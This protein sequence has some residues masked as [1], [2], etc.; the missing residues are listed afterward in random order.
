M[1]RMVPAN[2]HG[3][4]LAETDDYGTGEPIP[5]HNNVF[6]G[7]LVRIGLVLTSEDQRSAETV[8]VLTL[9]K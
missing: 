2:V 6:A 5:E 3:Q 4:A 9:W 8:G 1:L 7:V